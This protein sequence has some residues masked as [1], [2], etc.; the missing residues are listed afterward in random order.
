MRAIPRNS[1]FAE[2]D[3]HAVATR[4]GSGAVPCFKSIP[5]GWY[6]LCH[7]GDLSHGP[8]AGEVGRMRVAGFRDAAGC[9]R[10]ID[11]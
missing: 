3:P 5:Q 11:A 1:D 2:S 8:V 4:N 10:V 7:A 6:Y 9:A